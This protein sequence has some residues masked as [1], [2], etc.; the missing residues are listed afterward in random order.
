MSGNKELE[1]LFYDPKS[2]FVSGTKFLVFYS[3]HNT[4]QFSSKRIYVFDFVTTIE[5]LCYKR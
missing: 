3:T 5:C 2:G 1:K 4:F